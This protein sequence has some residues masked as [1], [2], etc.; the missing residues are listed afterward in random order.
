MIKL[1]GLVTGKKKLD[2]MTYSDSE[3]GKNAEKAL[4]QYADTLGKASQKI[5]HSMITSVK[6]G[7]Y[8]PLDLQVAIKRNKPSKAHG[9]ETDF[10]GN[11]W[12]K[13]RDKFR[14]YTP[15]GKLGR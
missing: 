1:S 8:Q 5:I 6:T 3:A 9:Y 12:L 15:K 7:E 13:I 14:K 11:L 4:N 10:I 2:E